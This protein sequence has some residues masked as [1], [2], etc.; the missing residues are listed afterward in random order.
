MHLS[1]YRLLLSM[2]LLL[3]AGCGPSAE[4]LRARKIVEP[5]LVDI[6]HR[7]PHPPIAK[8]RMHSTFSLG[9]SYHSM[10]GRIHARYWTNVPGGEVCDSFLRV[11]NKE[12]KFT[13]N[14]SISEACT[15]RV[16][17]D[18]VF[19]SIVGEREN[20]LATIRFG[21]TDEIV[22]DKR[23]TEVHVYLT[24]TLDKGRWWQCGP[25]ESG[26]IKSFC[27]RRWHEPLQPPFPSH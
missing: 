1:F 15:P 6:F 24:Y 3:L 14:K 7:L 26:R 9:G 23:R 17:E 10:G 16:W 13:T 21:A 22:G 12:L 4:E 18:R 5:A 8:V 20:G 19:H 11:L 25:N 2:L 27:H